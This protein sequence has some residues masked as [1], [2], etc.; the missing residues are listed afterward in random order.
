MLGELAAVVPREGVDAF[1]Q[2][3][4]CVHDGAQGRFGLTTGD[5]AKTYQTGLALDQG[6]DPGEAAADD[7]VAFPVAHTLACL[8]DRR[9][10]PDTAPAEPLP[11]AG[12]PVAATTALAASQRLPRRSAAPTVLGDVLIDALVADRH[13]AAAG[14][15]FGTLLL[16]HPRLDHR[17][18]A[19]AD[20]RARTRDVTAL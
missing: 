14:N 1:S 6:D 10:L 19:Q 20:A 13:L 11:F 8:D 15:L 18:I 3:V 7:R 12:C 4:Q 9:T 5:A 2:R 17:P 16:A